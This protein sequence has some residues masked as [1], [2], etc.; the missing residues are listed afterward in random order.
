LKTSSDEERREQNT[1]ESSSPVSHIVFGIKIIIKREGG[2]TASG[3]RN[4]SLLL[5][6]SSRKFI[7]YK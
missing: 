2:G 4:C 7:P 1:T 3:M 6:A 5:M